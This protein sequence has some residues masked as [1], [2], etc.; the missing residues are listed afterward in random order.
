MLI[1]GVFVMVGKENGV[2]VKF[3]REVKL[4]LNV[5]C[6]CYRL[7]FVCGDVND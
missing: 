7:V 6:I 2:V 3:K 5:Y 4:L 1:D